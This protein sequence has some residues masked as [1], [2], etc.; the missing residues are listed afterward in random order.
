MTDFMLA[1]AAITFFT[2]GYF[3]T[4]RFSSML[5]ELIPEDAVPEETAENGP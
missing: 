2:F 1:L 4:D 5:E 3:V